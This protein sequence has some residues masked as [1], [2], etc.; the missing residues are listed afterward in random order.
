MD[1]NAEFDAFVLRHR[2]ITFDHAALDLNSTARRVH[3]ACELNQDTVARPL[4][5]S[6]A[7]L[8]D[9]GFQKFTTMRIEPQQGAFLIG[10]HHSA[11]TGHVTGEDG[12]KPSFD[13]SSGHENAPDLMC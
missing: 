9:F 4:D 1:A 7:M 5:D 6:A 3:G 10:S 13:P 2:C 12:R 11:V 8:G